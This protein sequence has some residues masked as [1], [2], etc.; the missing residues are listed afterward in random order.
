MFTCRASPAAGTP[1]RWSW[2]R[3]LPGAPVAAAAWGH[4]LPSGSARY[5]GDEGSPDDPARRRRSFSL[6]VSP[7]REGVHDPGRGCPLPPRHGWPL[8]R[9]TRVRPEG[10]AAG[11]PGSGYYIPP[12]RA[13]CK[14]PNPSLYENYARKRNSW[15]R[16]CPR[17]V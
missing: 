9:V 13:M 10:M 14:K 15:S 4:S 6:A 2:V 11:K 5:A 1:S 17:H 12:T 7:G 16:L 8:R 3:K